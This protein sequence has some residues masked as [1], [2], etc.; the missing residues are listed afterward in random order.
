M[1]DSVQDPLTGSCNCGDIRYRVA[2]PFRAQIACHCVQ[3]QKHTQS[4]F[5]LV[6][7]VPA[8][9]F[10]LTAGTPAKWTKTADSGN[11]IDCYFCPRC[12]NRIYHLNP[13]QPDLVRLKLGTLDDTRVIKPSIH[14]WTES[15]QAWYQIPEGVPSYPQQ[16]PPRS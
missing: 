11:R 5:S 4:A 9:D 16:M 12:G 10:T 8:S 6:G 2:S 7:T 14:I 15:K 1:N 13:L 3:C